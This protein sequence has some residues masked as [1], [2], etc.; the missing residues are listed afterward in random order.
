LID[1]PMGE[2]AGEV[3]SSEGMKMVGSILGSGR[4]R[5]GGEE[6]QSAGVEEVV[7]EGE[8]EMH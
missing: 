5:K 1:G 4:V 8:S 3:E 7:E 6:G 2:M